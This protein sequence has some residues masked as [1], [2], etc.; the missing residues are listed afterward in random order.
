MNTESSAASCPLGA[1][2]ALNQGLRTTDYGLHPAVP[3]LESLVPSSEKSVQRQQKRW[4][5]SHDSLLPHRSQSQFADGTK[6]LTK[7]PRRPLSSNLTT[8]ETLA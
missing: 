3:D 4:D 6:I 5:S 1:S 2:W 8:P 7:R